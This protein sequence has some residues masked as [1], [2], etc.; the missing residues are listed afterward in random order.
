MTP[1]L[2]LLALLAPQYLDFL[3]QLLENIDFSCLYMFDIYFKARWGEEILRK[4]LLNIESV[5]SSVF[6]A[7]LLCI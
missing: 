2:A 6:C 1:L 4:E 5:F 7:V 3:L